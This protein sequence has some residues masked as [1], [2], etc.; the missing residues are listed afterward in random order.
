MTRINGPSGHHHISH[1]PHEQPNTSSLD[2]LP[3]LPAQTG[4]SVVPMSEIA[5]FILPDSITASQCH[6][7]TVKKEVT[8]LLTMVT[9]HALNNGISGTT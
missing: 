4:T 6:N 1:A 7:A 3:S 8:A 2:K 5:K 9:L